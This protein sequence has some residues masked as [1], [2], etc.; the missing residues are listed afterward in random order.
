MQNRDEFLNSPHP[1]LYDPHPGNGFD[2]GS[3]DP[4]PTRR[5]K[6]EKMNVSALDI[7]NISF[8]TH[9]FELLLSQ[10]RAA[11]IEP[12]KVLRLRVGLEIIC[13]P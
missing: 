7:A 10:I 13:Q 9:W 2:V 3:A 8:Q 6:H 1:R 12:T 11:V 4:I 5:F